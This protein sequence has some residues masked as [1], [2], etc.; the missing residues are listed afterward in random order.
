[1]EEDDED[2]WALSG[3]EEVEADSMG[4]SWD[5]QSHTARKLEIKLVFATPEALSSTNYGQ[6]RLK[7]KIRNLEMF[8]SAETG[9][10]LGS[11]SL[12]GSKGDTP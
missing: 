8:V 3:D 4:F 10:R 2:E 12:E 7:C 5:L 9:M 1:M 6:D 11:D